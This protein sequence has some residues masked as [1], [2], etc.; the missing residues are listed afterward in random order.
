MTISQQSQAQLPEYYVYLVSGNAAIGKSVK[1]VGKIKPK[2]YVFKNDIVVLKKGAELTLLD[3]S[4]GFLLLNTAGEYPYS[5]LSKLATKKNN[6]GITNAYLKLLFHELLDPSQD[7]E[8]FKKENIAGVSGGVSRGDDCL[9]RVFP[10]NGL[11]TSAPSIIF[12][13]HKTSPSSNY[14]FEIY[15]GGD[16]KELVKTRVR[17]TLYKVNF[18]EALQG[19][20][21]IYRWRVISEDGDCEDEMPIYFEL[22]TPEDEQKQVEQLTSS[23]MGNESL[24]IQLQ[25][26][27][28]LEKNALIHAA[29]SRYAA[30]VKAQ[31]DNKA[32]L[33]SY[34]IFLLNYGF[35]AEARAVWR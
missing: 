5:R 25:Q 32:L 19:N 14:S 2:S 24:E 22:L 33:K 27:D 15:P 18:K 3:K 23:L 11:K 16:T 26:V 10:I 4:G 9:N 28:R 1:T 7:F 29:S 21:G 8:K 30:L 35:E 31:P 13:W 34:V 17:D 20:P 6:P 12:K